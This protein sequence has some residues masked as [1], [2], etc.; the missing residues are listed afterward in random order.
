MNPAIVNCHERKFKDN[1]N[2][3]T[4]LNLKINNYCLVLFSTF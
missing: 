1:Y 4:F 2:I 3:Y